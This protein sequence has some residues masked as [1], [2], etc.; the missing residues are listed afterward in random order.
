MGEKTKDH[1]PGGLAVYYD[2]DTV[3]F[4]KGQ[5][6]SLKNGWQGSS[7]ANI[8][9]LKV[10]EIGEYTQWKKDKEDK[11]KKKDYTFNY[12]EVLHGFDF[13]WYDDAEDR[14]KT[15]DLIPPGIP[16]E[17]RGVGIQVTDEYFQ[18]AYNVAME[19]SEAPKSDE[20]V[21]F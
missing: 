15:G 14:Y 12:A 20:T 7:R 11:T 6:N 5:K 19:P 2:D 18:N 16:A 17:D 1:N 10:Y 8:V 3:Q 4:I 13:Y 21:P 9:L